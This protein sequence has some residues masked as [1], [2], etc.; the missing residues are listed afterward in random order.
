[1][2]VVGE[3]AIDPSATGR[4]PL[5]LTAAAR[6]RVGESHPRHVGWMAC[7]G[8]NRP[9]LLSMTCGNL[10]G[11]PWPARLEAPNADR[12]RVSGSNFSSQFQ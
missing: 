1:M 6:R 7:R 2:A 10:D 5:R 12:Y 8:A 4:Q 11:N 9:R 3:P